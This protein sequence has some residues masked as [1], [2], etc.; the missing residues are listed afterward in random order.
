MKRI[1]KILIIRFRQ[2]GDSVL[3]LPLCSS[4]KQ[5][6]PHAE[7]HLVLNKTIASMYEGHPAIDQI[8]TFDKKQND[9]L[10]LYIYRVWKIVRKQDYDVVIDM[11][12]T[13]KTLLFSFFSLKSPYRIGISK[14]YSFL[15]LNYRMNNA[16]P[17]NLV[18][19]VTQNLMLASPLQEVAPIK[20]TYEFR[21]YVSDDEK[22]RFRQQM[23]DKGIDFNN[24][25]LL[26]GVT[27][28]LLHKRWTKSSMVS[29]LKWI[30]RDFSNIQFIFNYTAGQEELDAETVF[31]ELDLPSAVKFDI[32][33]TSLR[34]LMALCS[35][36]SFY[37]GNEGG[38]RH[39]AQALGI[40]SY[41][42]FSLSSPKSKWLP[43]NSVMADG[44]SPQ[45]CAPLGQ[46][47][48]LKSDEAF[49]VITPEKVYELLL[50]QLQQLGPKIDKNIFVS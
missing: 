36:C 18:N 24:P 12:S 43:V 23:I 33:A 30:M 11:R 46:L 28:K 25:I 9:N 8:I 45:E 26:V 13:V 16:D 37:F 44:I 20:Y 19:R 41:A 31:K 50:P 14:P 34:E 42:I 47:K 35:N 48:K 22:R 2:I 21:L 5:S 38:A 29:V 49:S 6:F 10:F 1:T 32:K 3:T 39:I 4:L 7:V 15:F 17:E 40:P 27:T